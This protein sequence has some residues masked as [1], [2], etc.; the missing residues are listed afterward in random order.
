M[1]KEN[2][3][4]RFRKIEHD[5]NITKTIMIDIQNLLIEINKKIPKITKGY[6]WGEYYEL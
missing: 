1:D 5:I 4:I 2:I 6:I 3:E